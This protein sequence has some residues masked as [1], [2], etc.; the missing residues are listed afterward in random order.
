MKLIKQDSLTNK[1]NSQ[2]LSDAFKEKNL[3][4]C[5]DRYNTTINADQGYYYDDSYNKIKKGYFKEYDESGIAVEIDLTPN[6]FYSQM[7]SLIN[8][9][10]INE[11]TFYMIAIMNFYSK[12]LNKLIIVKNTFELVNENFIYDNEIKISY[13]E[14]QI[15]SWFILSFILSF[16][17]LFFE[18]FQLKKS[19]KVDEEKSKNINFIRKILNFFTNHFKKPSFST[20]ISK[21]NFY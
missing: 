16:F 12:N 13:L 4:G 7:N 1:C 11:N 19:K 10:W 15:D 8:K 2:R 6:K 21:K 5:L 9:K 20:L 18:F 3:Y 17:C 14:S